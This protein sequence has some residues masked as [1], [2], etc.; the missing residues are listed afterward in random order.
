MTTAAAPVSAK[1][2]AE[3]TFTRPRM[4]AITRT[5]G[6]LFLVDR[7]S[8]Y[9]IWSTFE[10]AESSEPKAL[11]QAAQRIVQRMTQDMAKAAKP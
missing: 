7:A 4:Q 6:T 11:N 2:A 10:D 1:D 3:D 5:R 9:V 8:H